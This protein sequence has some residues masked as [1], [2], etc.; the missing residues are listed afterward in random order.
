[1]TVKLKKFQPLVEEGVITV[2]AL[3]KARDAAR[4]RG[5]EVETV[6]LKEFGVPRG[7]LLA[8]LSRHFGCESIQYDERLPVPSHLFKGLKSDVLARSQWFPVM[9]AGPT[10]VIA[11]V[12]PES[13]AVRSEAMGLIPAGAYEFRVAL[14]EDI[15]WYIQDYLH[16]RPEFLIGI[17]R[18]GLALWRNT[19][20]HWRTRLACYRTDL[21]SARTGLALLRWGLGI[22]ALSD[23]LMRIKAHPLKPFYVLMLLAGIGFST[24]GLAAY[25]RVRRSRMSTPGEQTLVEVTGATLHFAQDYHLEGA[26]RK[27]LKGTM[28]ARLGDFVTDYSTILPPSP[29]S[30][31]R[32]HLARERNMLAAQ[33]TLAA[34]YRTLFSRAR[35]GLAFIRTGISF[36]GLGFAMSKFLRPGPYSFLDFFLISAGFLMTVDGFLWYLPV[37]KE[38]YGIT[39][40]ISE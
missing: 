9:M 36:M 39:R 16:A 33:R 25:V 26:A 17:E 1:M 21:A 12:N 38:K 30:K 3:L 29:A 13:R 27:T 5:V 7:A 14:A 35:T 8:A 24:G 28:L 31:E 34:C 20:A 37:R 11:A 2:E 18:T 22:V 32:T 6:L 10:A 15:Q 23:A 40:N 19:M 4:A